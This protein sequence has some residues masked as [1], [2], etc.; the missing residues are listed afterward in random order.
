MSNRVAGVFLLLFL[1]LQANA[2]FLYSPE[3]GV[4]DLRRWNLDTKKVAINDFWVFYEDKL[5]EPHEV[6]IKRGFRDNPYISGSNSFYGTG[7]GTYVLDVV[8]PESVPSLAFQLPQVYSSY[9]LWVNNQVVA[10]SGTVA[11]TSTESVPQWQTQV[12]TINHLE[13]TLHI[14]MQVAN[15]HHSTSGVREPVY[16]GPTDQLTSHWNVAKR[17]IM[18]EVLLL[19]GEA[20]LFAGIFFLWKRKLNALYFSLLCL[21]WAIRGVFSNLYLVTILEPDFNWAW[22]VRIEYISLFTTAIFGVLF[23]HQLFKNI[24]NRIVQ[25]VLL[26]INLFFIVFCLLSPP[27]TFTRW[28]PVYLAVIAIVLV[29]GIFIIIQALILEQ[30]GVW[31]LVGSIFAGIIIFSYDILSFSGLFEYNYAVLSIGYMT[32]FLLATIA[33]LLNLN[34]IKS[35]KPMFGSMLRY[36]DFYNNKLV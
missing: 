12:A 8:L 3:A 24:S 5:L 27:I 9:K 35:R 14:V 18:I 31:Y 33:L 29:Y 22:M 21:S 1:C 30:R 11:R 2:Q 17:S 20:L 28:L 19:I 10:T 4:L 15:F 16:L 7:Y 6:D 26:G 13:D 36:E 23:L 34:I 25:Y 32:I